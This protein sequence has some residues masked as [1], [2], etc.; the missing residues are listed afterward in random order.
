M[1]NKIAHHLSPG[2]D[3]CPPASSLQ[4][5]HW[6]WHSGA[7]NIPLASRVSCAGHAPSWIVVLLLTG[8]AWETGKSLT[9]GKHYTAKTE[10]SLCYQHN[11]HSKAKNHSTV[12]ATGSKL[13]LSQPRSRHT[14]K[15]SGMTV[16]SS[17]K[18]KCPSEFLRFLSAFL[19]IK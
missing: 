11:S 7:W 14:A 16:T 17:N 3:Q 2:S 9:W 1:H 19:S 12:P 6:V 15:S 8:K 13:T 4:F 18:K 10:A 5:T